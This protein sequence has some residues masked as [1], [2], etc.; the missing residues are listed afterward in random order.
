MQPHERERIERAASR[1]LGRL[2]GPV[3]VA[4]ILGSGFRP[5]LE[6]LEGARRMRYEEIEGL[7]PCE[8][9]GHEGEIVAGAVGGARVAL[10]SGRIHLYEGRPAAETTAPVELARAL[11]ADRILLT[12][13]AGATGQRPLPGE[14]V[15]VEDHLN[16]TG[17]NPLLDI[18][19]RERCPPFLPMGDA[20][21]RGALDL[22]EALAAGDA[23]G[24]RRCVLASVRGPSF[25]T[26]AEY[27]ALAR[28]G[29]DIV[30]MSCA[31]ETIAARAR[32]LRVLALAIV[33]NG[34][35]RPGERGADGVEVLEV[36]ETAVRARLGFFARLLAGFAA[37]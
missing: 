35:A 13:A 31:L 2:G 29:A 21:D 24:V 25:E 22:A 20:Y 5:V 19:L 1:L 8:A 4:G 26:P 27:R 17:E 15:L 16:L 32:G 36:V 37:I 23:G 34:P 6:I 12:T 30:S 3:R 14:L 28:L 9:P 10:F 7:G 33:A 18:P 11:G